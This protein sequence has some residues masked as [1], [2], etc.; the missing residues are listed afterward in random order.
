MFVVFVLV[1]AINSRAVEFENEEG[2]T[3]P[4]SVRISSKG[5]S[6]SWPAHLAKLGE[7]GVRCFTV[8]SELEQQIQDRLGKGNTYTT[9]CRITESL[10]VLL[11]EH[12]SNSDPL[13]VLDLT[14]P[15]RPIELLRGLPWIERTLKD[16]SGVLHLIVGGAGLSLGFYGSTVSIF[17]TKTWKETILARQSGIDNQQY[18]VL[19]CPEKG[20]YGYNTTKKV[21]QETHR[22]EDQDGDG[23]E[24]IIVETVETSCSTNK[25]RTSTAVFLATDHGFKKAARPQRSRKSRGRP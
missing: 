8:S 15:G 17:S 2:Q 4:N 13:S 10:V 25:S 5:V 6:L 21:F 23:F 20:G 22:Y 14:R 16:K 1:S 3:N 18:D 11:A 7:E 24:D 19:E 12:G 9:A